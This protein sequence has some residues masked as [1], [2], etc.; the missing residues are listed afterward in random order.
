MS[1]LI[2]VA[3]LE[4]AAPATLRVFGARPFHTDGNVLALAFAPDGT[5]WSIEEPGVLRNWDLHAQKQIDWHP[6]DERATQWC[7]NVTA[8]LVATGSD[9]VAVW[10]AT[11]EQLAAWNSPSWVTAMT[12]SRNSQILATGHDDGALRLWDW[13][14]EKLLREFT[15]HEM[16]VS[17][18]A[19]SPEGD[20]LASAGEGRRI[21]IH[22][23]PT[24]RLLGTLD[25]H[26]DRIPALAWHPDNRRLVSAGWDT[27]ARVWDTETFAPII[28]LNSHSGQVHT[29]AFSPE[30]TRL[31]CADSANA[32]HLWD[33]ERYRTVRVLTNQAREAT[34]LAFSADGMRLAAGGAERVIHLWDARRDLE[35]QLDDD[36]QQNQASLAVSANGQRLY[37][38]GPG[39]ALRVWDSR[40]GDFV[41]GLQDA[42]ALRTFALSPDGQWLAASLLG[43]DNPD[44]PLLALYH[45]QTGQRQVALDG[46][47]EPVST[48]AFRSDSQQLA[49]ASF[50]SPDVWLWSVPDG[51]PVLLIPGAADDCSVQALAHHPN[52]RWL[53]VAGVDYLSTSGQDGL[54]ALWDLVERKEIRRFR[55][56]AS[57]LA[58]HPSGDQLAAASLQQTVRI[59]DLISGKCLLELHGAQEAVT[60]VAYSPDGRW[61]AAGSED[62]GVRLW[63]AVSGDPAAA[64]EVDSQVRALAFSADGRFLFTG[65]ANTSCHQLEVARLLSETA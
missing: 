23:V 47:R 44:R 11:G 12:F 48:L 46:P 62:H 63:D 64:V 21:Y 4:N 41:L 3:A 58:F 52:G 18:I 6:L 53:A 33:F 40:M 56:G 15:G 5:L 38:Q 34:C 31:A 8:R 17:A 65:N 50:Q 42:A 49:S 43:R 2:D 59:W 51:Q 57:Q 55:G 30:G 36:P 7:F 27:T 54:V 1:S 26:T 45:A 24:G 22:E 14:E 37:S 35:P 60:C 19:F 29:L 39:T 16:A 61:I 10:V 20:K 9:E 28:L 13:R 25:G 32:V